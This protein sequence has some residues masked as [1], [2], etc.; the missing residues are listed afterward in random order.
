MEMVLVM[1][2]F[3]LFCYNYLGTTFLCDHVTYPLTTLTSSRSTASSS[4]RPARMSA[5]KSIA[6]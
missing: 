4:W 6:P 2:V 1:V 5:C 3:F